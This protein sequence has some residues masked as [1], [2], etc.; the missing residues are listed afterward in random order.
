MMTLLKTIGV[1]VGLISSLLVFAVV[2]L[3]A[4]NASDRTK[5]PNTLLVESW[6]KQQPVESNENGFTYAMA[7]LNATKENQSGQST[8]ALTFN[9]QQNKLTANFKDACQLTDWDTCNA[10]FSHNSETIKRVIHTHQANIKKYNTLIAMP[11]WQESDESLTTQHLPHWS[12]LFQLRD[13]SILAAINRPDST[14]HKID[15]DAAIAF[16]NKDA[17]FWNNVYHSSRS[18]LSHTI[19]NNMLKKQL[20]FASTLVKEN[21]NIVT[22]NTTWQ[23]AF[24]LSQRD[25]ERI[26]SG[27]WLFSRNIMQQAVTDAQKNSAPF[28]EKWLVNTFVHL[29][30]DDNLRSEYFVNVVK[31]PVLASS[32][33]L[34]QPD[35]CGTDNKLQ[36]LWQLRYNPIGKILSCTYYETDLKLRVVNMNN[37]IE[38]LRNNLMLP[39]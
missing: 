10:F 5:S 36:Q 23:S 9:A 38:Q 13:L 26:F 30:D 2:C 19:A 12:L 39:Q 24:T 31:E 34:K 1:L 28:Y 37:E 11:D 22:K 33:T 18:V 35:Y 29:I 21:P 3:V 25:F 16:L 27:E 15:V 4:I 8:T 17:H 14:P 6:L 7:L 32:S 20:S